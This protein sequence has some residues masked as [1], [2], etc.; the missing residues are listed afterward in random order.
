MPREN[1]VFRNPPV[2]EKAIGRFG[3]GPILAHQRNALTHAV[4][5]LLEQLSETLVESSVSELA[6]S[7]FLSDP[8]FG[9]RSGGRGN[10]G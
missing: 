8:G 2:G 5:E 10:P 4:R 1:L 7:Q 3:M 9:L 6:A